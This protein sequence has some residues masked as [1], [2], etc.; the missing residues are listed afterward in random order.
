LP[1]SKDVFSCLATHFLF[2]PLA[3]NFSKLYLRER[4]KWR[5]LAD[6]IAGCGN[7]DDSN[8]GLKNSGDRHGDDS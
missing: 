6:V 4:V 3:D 1:G 5:Q 2:S 8:D 7:I